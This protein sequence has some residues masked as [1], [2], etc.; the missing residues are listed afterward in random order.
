M[1]ETTNLAARI[2]AEFSAVEE[3][4]KKFQ[5][6]QIGEHQERQKRLQKLAEVFDELQGVW[7]PRLELLTKRFGDRVK[8]TPRIIPSTREATFDFKSGVASVRLRLSASTDRD[9]RTVV[10]GYNLD[11]IPVLMRFDSHAEKEFPLD[12][13][14]KKAVA[15]WIDDRLV[16]FVRTY[17]S[18]VQNEFYA[19]DNTV[20]DPVAGVRF[21]KVIAGATLDW[22]GQKF[23]FLGEETRR[24]FARQNNIPLP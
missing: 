12:A 23:Y 11:I 24:E 19:K 7:G 3:K 5:S 8:V 21:P 1:A 4:M 2:D 15:Q 9:I 14:D 20:E 6:E 10:L 16:D 17:L 22:K 18:L 13:V